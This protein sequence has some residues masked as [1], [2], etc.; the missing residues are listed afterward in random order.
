MN[1]LTKIQRLNK[2]DPGFWPYDILFDGTKPYNFDPSDRNTWPRG[3]K[4][5][6]GIE[7]V[8]ST[9]IIPEENTIDNREGV[10][11]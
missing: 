11:G 1:N 9:V 8:E 7:A 5:L 4:R 10:N 6:P 3:K 2:D